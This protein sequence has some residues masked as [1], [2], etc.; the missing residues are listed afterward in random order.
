MDNK[1]KI[2]VVAMTILGLAGTTAFA[3][4]SEESGEGPEKFRKKAQGRF[5]QA[6]EEELNLT[7]EQVEQIKAHRETQR[8]ANKEVREK[9]KT[10]MKTLHTEIAKPD[11]DR[12]KVQSIAAEINGYRGQLFAQHIDGVL[13]FKEI[14]TPEQFTKMEELREKGKEKVRKHLGK[15]MDWLKERHGEHPKEHPGE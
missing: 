14:L 2:A 10:S 12:A 15:R 6:M 8:K 4:G 13:D 1:L 7:P 11:T 9:L 5:L 3:Y